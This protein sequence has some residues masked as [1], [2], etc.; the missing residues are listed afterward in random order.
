MNDTSQPEVKREPIFLEDFAP[1]DAEAGVGLALRDRQGRYLFFLAGTRHNCPAGELFYAGIG[2]HRESGET[3]EQCAQREV[4][5]E[6]GVGVQLLPSS[7]TWTIS[8]GHDVQSIAVSHLPRP[9]ALF[10]MIHPQG[11]PNEGRRYKIVIFRAQLQQV[12]TRL[13]VEEVG[14]LI[15]LKTWQVISGVDCRPTLGELL[16]EGAELPLDPLNIDRETIL[17]PLGTAAAMADILRQPG[18]FED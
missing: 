18:E 5:E 4:Q 13:Q 9:L 3:W 17:Y 15:A 16:E 12:P 8:S 2:G 6:L 10:E 1:P 14:G 7:R 11:T